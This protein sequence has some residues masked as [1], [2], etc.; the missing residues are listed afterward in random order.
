MSQIGR[1]ACGQMLVQKSLRT[2]NSEEA[3]LVELCPR[4]DE[5]NF[6]GILEKSGPVS[7]RTTVETDKFGLEKLQ[8]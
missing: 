5:A 6:S 8:K 7:I 3:I 1:C 4:C 2:K